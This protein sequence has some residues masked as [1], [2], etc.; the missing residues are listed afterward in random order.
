MDEMQST[1]GQGL[2][3]AGLVLGII[4][5]PLGII[6]C[7]FFLGILFGIVG[8]VLS[9]VALGQAKRGLGPK[10]LIIA[11]LVCSAVGFTLSTVVG[12]A[13]ARGGAH[14]VK[15]IIQEKFY[16]GEVFDDIHHDV[17]DVLH[18][19]ESDSAT[20]DEK[21]HDE[22]KELTDTLKMLEGESAN[23]EK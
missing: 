15:Q 17:D 4:A 12:A 13:L 21:Q 22:L 18:D 3:I 2:G 9:L 14:I 11:A 5:I 23:S 10:N 19:L 1:A 8:I 16:G 20:W 6:P 7:T